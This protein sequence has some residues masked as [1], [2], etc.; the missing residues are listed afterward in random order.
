MSDLICPRLMQ[1]LGSFEEKFAL[2]KRWRCETKENKVCISSS[3]LEFRHSNLE[4]LLRVMQKLVSYG[5]LSGSVFFVSWS[6]CATFASHYTNSWALLTNYS[7][8]G[9][10]RNT[11]QKRAPECPRGVQRKNKK[12]KQATVETISIFVHI[13][14]WENCAVLGLVQTCARA[15]APFSYLWVIQTSI[16]AFNYS[17][18]DH[19]SPSAMLTIW[20]EDWG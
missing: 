18:F 4:M 11:H 1:A 9:I 12:K 16:N 8:S 19:L 14:A 5:R 2:S 7:T 15:P 17:S 6:E 20:A 13:L 3:A 10:A